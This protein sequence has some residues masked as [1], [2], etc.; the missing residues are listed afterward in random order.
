M[1]SRLLFLLA[2]CFLLT[3]CRTTA[4]VT[5][6][7]GVKD[8]I[9]PR[10]LM[11]SESQTVRFFFPEFFQEDGSV[12]S[13]DGIVII[14]PNGETMVIDGF[15]KEAG[16][17]YCQFIK[18][19]GITRIDYLV[20]THFHGDH[21]GTFS[22]ILD[23]FEIGTLFTNGAPINTG[24]SKNLC[25]K[26]DSMGIVPVVLKKNDSFTIG[27]DKNQ[28]NLRVFSPLLSEEDLYTVFYNP[29]RTEKKINNTSLVFK[30]SFKDFSILFT[31]D[32]Y[33][34]ADRIMC[35]EFGSELQSTILK[36]PHH[37]EFYTANSPKLL[38][39]VKP[40]AAVV[41][42]TRYVNGIISMIYR[43]HKIQ[44]LY[45]NTPGFILIESDGNSYTVSQQSY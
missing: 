26:L 4:P 1:K 19:L 13:G 40:E 16:E 11:D 42:D 28:C 32:I 45:R 33:K 21:I 8:F 14:F 41:Q 30:I 36:A 37:G 35:R 24:T 18:S 31:G 6:L 27:S 43:F 39:T 7:S 22:R 12:C 38:S 29:G 9:A 5:E 34:Q 10:S 20:A 17:Q 23:E 2:L 15:V 3:A 25:A 44:M